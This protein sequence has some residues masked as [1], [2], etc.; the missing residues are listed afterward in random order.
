VTASLYMVLNVRHRINPV[1]Q[2]IKPVSRTVLSEEISIML[3]NPVRT[4]LN[5]DT[6]FGAVTEPLN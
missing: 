1:R 2:T 4:Q 5:E 3:S 6:V